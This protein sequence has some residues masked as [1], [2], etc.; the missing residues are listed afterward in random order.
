[1]CSLT[2]DDAPP[3]P[4][5]PPRSDGIALAALLAAA[6]DPG[7]ARGLVEQRLANVDHEVLPAGHIH[8][9][10]GELRGDGFTRCH[11]CYRPLGEADGSGL[12]AAVGG[13]E[14][15]GLKRSLEFA[16]GDRNAQ[17]RHTRSAGAVPD[18]NEAPAEAVRCGVE[19]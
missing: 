11:E 17:Q 6:N 12:A 3:L 14:P 7:A 5:L 13:L 4:P 9:R 1:M 2:S 19:T 15:R 8:R 18:A 10:L 16:V